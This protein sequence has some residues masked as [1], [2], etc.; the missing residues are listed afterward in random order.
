[1]VYCGFQDTYFSRLAKSNTF[2]PEQ[3]LP[4]LIMACLTGLAGTILFGACTQEKCNWFIPLIGSFG[5]LFGFICANS[6]TFAYLV[7]VYLARG[8][9]TLVVV[10]GFKNLAAFAISYAIIPWNTNSGYTIPFGVLGAII[11]GI[12]LL[13]LLLW[14]KGQAIRKWTARKYKEAEETHHGETF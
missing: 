7:D 5:T 1:M 11:G 10:N 8:D 13:M 14:W 9:A 12:H 6:I 4:F 2:T 3:R